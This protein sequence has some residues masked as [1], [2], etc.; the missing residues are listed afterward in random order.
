MANLRAP[1]PSSADVVIIGGGASGSSVA[2]Q[3]AKRGADVL[4]LESGDISQGASGRNGGLLDTA[5][6]PRLPLAEYSYRSSALYPDLARELPLD[7]EYLQSGAFWVILEGDDDADEID[8]EFEEHLALGWPVER[9]TREQALALSPL[10]PEDTAYGW[11][12]PKDGQVNP[13]MLT[14]ALAAAAVEHGGKVR[15]NCTVTGIRCERD[16]VVGVDTEDGPVACEHLVVAAEPWSRPIL[17][18]LGLDA[19][20][21]PQRG[22]IFVTEP[23]P[24]LMEC[25]CLYGT[26][27]YIYWRQT[28]HGGFTIGGCRPQDVHGDWLLGGPSAG[29]TLDIQKMILELMQRVHPSIADVNII[30]WWGGVMG[31]TP[32]GMPV[33]GRTE[34]FPNVVCCFGFCPNGILCAPMT[35]RV[36]ADVV[37][38][39]EPEVPLEPYRLERFAALS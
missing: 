22:T 21:L 30:R 3:L 38:G 19:P 35:G 16:Q 34:R 33:L 6:D 15:Q 31:F 13:I 20:V 36:I 8:A 25:S 1:L 28:R 4:L 37:T 2:H 26:T 27:A 18:P 11:M 17:A 9:Y 5:V 39:A 7:I 14:H 29:T 10:F 24:P 32:D 23:L 12:R